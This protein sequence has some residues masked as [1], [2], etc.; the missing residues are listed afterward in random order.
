MN[1][2]IRIPVLLFFAAILIVACGRYEIAYSG[3][4]VVDEFTMPEVNRVMWPKIS[5]PARVIVLEFQVIAP[6]VSKLE[7]DE[8][9]AFESY[10]CEGERGAYR[11]WS[12]PL[13]ADELSIAGASQSAEALYTIVTA[14]G[15]GR[16]A[17]STSSGDE[18]C[19]R[20]VRREAFNRHYYS[21]VI[22]L[23]REEWLE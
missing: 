1:G 7:Y 21:N 6:S 5:E 18:I 20:L 11:Y 4:E 14:Q 15:I 17:A 22:K 8:F 9:L 16:L 19:V 10:A 2:R 13:L 12:N 23:A 3:S